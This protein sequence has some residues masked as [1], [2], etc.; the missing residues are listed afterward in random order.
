MKQ[1]HELHDDGDEIL[2]DGGPGGVA[3]VVA[4]PLGGDR[5]AVGS[6]GR[7][8]GVLGSRWKPLRELGLPAEPPRR[9]WLL[10]RP[11]EP[12]D[13]SHL[14][15]GYLP[16][17]KVG[18][19]AAAGGAGKTMALVQLAISVAT[20]RPWLGRY[21][22]PEDARGRVVLALAEED[23]E[24]A[25]RRLHAVRRGLALSEAE[26]AAVLDRIVLLPMAGESVQLVA[27]Q[28]RDGLAEE[29]DV[30]RELRELLSEGPDWKLVVLDPL[31]RWAGPETETDNFAATR[32]VGAV[33]SLVRA[34]GGPTVLLAHHTTKAARLG[35]GASDATA[36]RGASALT[37]G[38]RWVATL[39][40][41]DG[42][43]SLSLVKTNY[44]APADDCVLKRREGGLLEFMNDGELGLVRQ[45]AASEREGAGKKFGR[46]NVRSR[47]GSEDAEEINGF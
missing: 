29:T 40:R 33:E 15:Q 1:H 7:K 3:S 36:A 45:G 44:S 14:P 39:A 20:G 5:P 43:L 37:D 22:V 27:A 38:V 10:Q 34:P 41:G 47:K 9:R 23:Q 4:P 46:A 17:G 19:L 26:W 8:P 30:L 6:P 13:G 21:V 35:M 2:T 32:F 24:E 28:R 11:A 16:L 31:S 42:L 12:H 18:M 25:H